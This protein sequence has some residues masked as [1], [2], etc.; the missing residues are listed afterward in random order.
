VTPNLKSIRPLDAAIVGVVIL[1]LTVAGYL[2][3]SIWSHN[4]AVEDSTPLSRAVTEL[5]EMIDKKPD[6]VN[7]RMELAQAYVTM[8]RDKEATEQ[9]NQVLKREKSNVAALSGLG[10]VA[11]RQRDWEQSQEY[12]T[13]AIKVMEGQPNTKVT[14]Q[15]ATA[16]FYLGNSYLEQKKYEE[17]VGAFKESLRAN[18]SAS[19]TY[20]LLAVAFKGLGADDDHKAQLEMALAFDPMMPEANYDYGSVL[21]EEG[22]IAEAA[23]HFRIAADRAPDRKEPRE[24]LAR[25]GTFDQRMSA[26]RGLAATDAEAALIEVRVAVALEPDNVEA[27][28]MLAEIYEDSGDNESAAEAYRSVLQKDSDNEQAQTAL[29]KVTDGE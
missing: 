25:L 29:K 15:W 26:A 8:G 3:Y 22:A 12:W 13:R 23:Q 17:A 1:V 18:R 6:D 21:L 14:K 28:L 2:G 7:L 5:K 16:H 10:F 4:R 24:A 19:D 11:A 20:Y 9:Y 27:L